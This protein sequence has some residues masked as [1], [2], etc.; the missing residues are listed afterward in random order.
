MQNMYNSCLQRRKP[1]Q[2]D[3]TTEIWNSRTALKIIYYIY[4][5]LKGHNAYQGKFTQKKNSKKH[6][7]NPNMHHCFK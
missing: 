5:I 2:W 3:R 1:K 6:F 4:H 7:T